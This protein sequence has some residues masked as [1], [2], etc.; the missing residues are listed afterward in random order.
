MTDFGARKGDM[1]KSDYDAAKD[2]L[3]DDANKL[4][5]S[6]KAEVQDHTPKSHTHSESEISDLSHDAALIKAVAVDNAAIADG[7]V[8]VYRSGTGKLE[9]EAQA[10]GGAS[11]TDRGD[12]AAHDFTLTDFTTDN[13]WRDLNLSSIISTGVKLVHL[14]LELQDNSVNSL[15]QFRQKGRSNTVNSVVINTQISTVYVRGYFWLLCD[16]D[17]IIQYKGNPISMTYINV[18]VRGWIA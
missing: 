1:F 8:I 15:M 5:G 18:S 12:P 3:V 7:F 13:T 17:G 4:Q 9:Y 2:G 10:G 16:A 14:L 6:T 11:Y